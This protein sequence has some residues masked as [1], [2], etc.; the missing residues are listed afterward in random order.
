MLPSKLLE[1][2]KKVKEVLEKSD[3]IVLVHHDD[4]DGICSAALTILGIGESNKIDQR[5][6]LEK[7][8]PQILPH[9]HRNLNEKTTVIYV[10]LAS[11]HADKIIKLKGAENIIIIDHHDPKRIKNKKIYQINPELY[12]LTG[13]CDASA[14]TMTYIFFKNINKNILPHAFL[15]VIGSAEIPGPLKSLNEIPL[16]DSEILNKVKRYGYGDKQKYYVDFYGLRKPHTVLSSMLSTIA[17]IGYYMEG[18]KIALKTCL[19]GFDNISIEFY[20]K[21]KKIKSELFRK[22]F[23]KLYADGMKTLDYVQWFNVGKLFYNV[24]VKSIGLFTSQLKYRRIVDQNK[25]IIG[26]MDMNPEL[27][28]LGKLKENLVKVSGRV[29]K[30]LESKIKLGKFP[31]IEEVMIEAAVKVGGFADGH[32]VAAS[33]IIEKDKVKEFVEIFNETVKKKIKSTGLLKYFSK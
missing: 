8:F 19:E 22:A 30:G 24:G 16:K 14:S 10:D 2:I 29:P 26:F 12:G 6:C 31:G 28:G 1:D 5:I 27:P 25:Y 32:T 18:P 4:A 20:E 7:T 17:S 33:G 13:E 11:P 23:E 3:R 15:A 21:M 9:I